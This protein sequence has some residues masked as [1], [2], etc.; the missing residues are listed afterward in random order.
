MEEIWETDFREWWAKNR[1]SAYCSHNDEHSL[2]WTVFRESWRKG[3]EA[4]EAAE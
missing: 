3:W 2:I 1:I 4:R